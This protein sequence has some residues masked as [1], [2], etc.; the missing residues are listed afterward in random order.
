M[1]E[2]RERW[3]AG[4]SLVKLIIIWVVCAVLTPRLFS[5]PNKN[6]VPPELGVKIL[7]RLRNKKSLYY[8]PDTSLS[9]YILNTGVYLKSCL[10]IAPDSTPF[11]PAT[12]YRRHPFL[13]TVIKKYHRRL[14]GKEKDA[15]EI[16]NS[17]YQEKLQK[18]YFIITLFLLTSVEFVKIGINF[19]PNL[20]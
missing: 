4:E 15:N 3:G 8:V 1:S 20:D 9:L 10:F 2:C 11:S 13:F 17:F 16:Y 6:S 14:A 18:I 12:Y 5:T 19:F 7:F